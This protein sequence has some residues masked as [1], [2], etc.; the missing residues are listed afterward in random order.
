MLIFIYTFKLCWDYQG[1]FLDVEKSKESS[2][3]VEGE[4]TEEEWEKYET[5]FA[6]VWL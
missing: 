3:G 1:V 6:W 5:M 4:K 2:S